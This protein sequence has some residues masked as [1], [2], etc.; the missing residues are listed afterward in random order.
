MSTKRVGGRMA[1]AGR[2]IACYAA[3]M[4]LSAP[5]TSGSTLSPPS[6]SPAP[7]SGR[8][9]ALCTCHLRFDSFSSVSLTYSSLCS[10]VWLVRSVSVPSNFDPTGLQFSLI[11]C[12]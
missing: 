10:Y 2:S 6:S 12:A 9:A 3:V 4:L 5:A 7:R 1:A 11:L 8:A